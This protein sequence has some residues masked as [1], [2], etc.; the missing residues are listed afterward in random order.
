MNDVFNE[1]IEV[2]TQWKIILKKHIEEGEGQNVE[3]V[4]NCHVCELGKWI[5]GEGVKYNRLPSFE[6]MCIAHEQFH[7]SA[8]EVV[9]NTNTKNIDK[10]KSL[11]SHDGL[12]TQASTKLIKSLMDCSK[13]LSDSLV[14]GIRNVR[15]VKN[16]L[17]TKD[18][19]KIISV[20]G[21]TTTLETIRLMVDNNIGSIA[22]KNNEEFIGIITERGYLKNLLH[23]GLSTLEMPV[24]EMLDKDV[25]NIDPN[26]S[27]EQCMVLMTAAHLRHLPVIEDGKLVGMISIGDVVKEVVID[28]NEKISA[29]DE[30]KSQLEDYIHGHYGAKI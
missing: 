5:Y 3:H 1:A 15:K 2:H 25:I 11:M 8:A 22:V 24:Y 10:A 9:F 13:D 29:L 23:R 16:I 18:I 4:G 27:V 28:D 14:K 20:D 7:R 6:A 26:D 21:N 17:Q 30:T 19:N 12:F